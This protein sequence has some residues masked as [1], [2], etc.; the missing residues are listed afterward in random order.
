MLIMVIENRVIIFLMFSGGALVVSALAFGSSGPG[1][2]PGRVGGHCVVFLGKTLYS[3]CASFPSSVQMAP[4]NLM[5]G[6]TLR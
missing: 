2:S 3:S 4:A 1:S 5:L 6:V